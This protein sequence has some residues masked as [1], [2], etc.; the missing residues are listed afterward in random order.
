MK[1]YILKAIFFMAL[2]ATLFTGCVNDDDYSIPNLQCNEPVIATTKTVAAIYSKA[3]PVAKLYMADDVIEA[4]VV[5]SDKGGN[6]YKI[7]YLNSLD[8]EIGFSVA[9]NQ[10]SISTEFG[11]GRTVF[12]KLKGL[13]TQIRN[14]TLQIG[15][16]YNGNV[17][18][19]ATT[20]YKKCLVKSCAITEESN[21]V[22][23]LT[24][25]D[26]NDSK[27]GKLIEFSGVQFVEDALDQNYY[28]PRNLVG[29]ETNLLITDATGATL[30]F[31][32]GSYAEYS[33]TAVAYKSGKIRGILTKFGTT[34]QF[35]ARYETD[36]Q[37][38]EPRLEKEPVVPVDPIGPI[39]PT[40]PTQPLTG[41]LLFGGGDF[42]NYPDFAVAVNSAGLK[43]Y[44]TQGTGSGM[45][46]GNS[47][48]I[49]GTP[50]GNDFVFTV[51]A[52]AG[53]PTNATK[54]TF[55]VKGTSGKSLSINLYRATGGF[56]VFNVGN[57][58]TTT[59]TIKKATLNKTS[60]NG[61]NKYTGTINTNNTWVKVTLDI[62]NISINTSEG[63][64][65][66]ALKVGKSLAYDL[67]LDN[68]TIE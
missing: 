7:M 1:T 2:S 65:F 49:S 53:L 57:L 25:A 31:R 22:Q 14:N 38:T 33:G 39:G 61:S 48:K 30:L 4:K 63:T 16:L 47:L 27:I 62:S 17:G 37:L 45:N 55:F 9:I 3:T 11:V 68:F 54:I 67:N 40:A 43:T 56:D 19:I 21:L 58:A 52:P 24:L 10:V 12:I 35:V 6:F 60:G 34:Y 36:I 15:A 64:D 13:Y 42:E 8:G 26:I 41:S 50:A 28:N 18:Q 23:P 29:G 66:F 5:S 59:L 46:G 51:S 20:D 32:T 44:A